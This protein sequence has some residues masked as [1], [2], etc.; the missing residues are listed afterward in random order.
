MSTFSTSWK[1]MYHYIWSRFLLHLFQW[2]NCFVITL[3]LSSL[4]NH[5]LPLQQSTSKHIFCFHISLNRVKRMKTNAKHTL[6]KEHVRTIS[7]LFHWVKALSCFADW[8]A[9]VVCK[10]KHQRGHVRYVSKNHELLVAI[11]ILK[12]LDA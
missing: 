6:F 5:V 2:Y 9:D 1:C 11:S 7:H 4:T 3:K 8:K 12:P 10:K